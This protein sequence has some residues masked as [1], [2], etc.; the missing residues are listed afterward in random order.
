MNKLVFK[1]GDRVRIK[2]Y[3]EDNKLCDDWNGVNAAAEIEPF[4]SGYIASLSPSGVPRTKEGYCLDSDSIPSVGVCFD[5]SNFHYG[6]DLN[7]VL[8]GDENDAQ[9][10]NGREWRKAAGERV[11]DAP[12]G[13]A[14]LSVPK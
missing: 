12:E 13:E 4:S 14:A 2:N 9:A 1:V 10:A 5:E 6:H 3:I 11:W 8:R 7:G